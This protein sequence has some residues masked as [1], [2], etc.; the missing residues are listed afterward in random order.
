MRASLIKL[1]CEESFHIHC[2]RLVA[3]GEVLSD[4]RCVCGEMEK[5]VNR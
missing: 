2:F 5:R 1:S 4:Y 3:A